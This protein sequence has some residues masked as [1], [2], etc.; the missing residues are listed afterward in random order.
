M[1]LQVSKTRKNI[2]LKGNLVLL[3]FLVFGVLVNGVVHALPNF[4]E[5]FQLNNVWFY[6]DNEKQGLYYFMPK[7]LKLSQRDN[8]PL[9]GYDLFRYV[10]TKMTGDAG[11][12]RVRGVITF[13]VEKT[14]PLK[15]LRQAK[16]KLK[17]KYREV[18][19]RPVPL[20]EFS[21]SLIYST[22][23]TNEDNKKSGEIFGGISKANDGNEKEGQWHRRRFTIG[24]MSNTAQVFWDNFQNDRLQ[25]S[26]SYHWKGLGVIPTDFNKSNAEELGVISADLNDDDEWGKAFHEVVNTI[27]INISAKEYPK[28]FRKNETWQKLSMGHTNLTVYCYDFINELKK[29]LYSVTV[30]VKF[31][32]L[33]NQDYKEKVKFNENDDSY[34]KNISFRLAKDLDAGY[35]YRVKRLY[36]DGRYE[37][38]KWN[39]FNSQHLDVT[40]Y[41]N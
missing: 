17:A 24:L 18:N 30:E 19:F 31:K 23:E 11:K 26:L 40:Y 15:E 36:Q 22:T 25:L 4:A 10:G 8:K 27:P 6:P 35:K 3:G 5:G 39:H 7:E 12:F 14:S 32:T 28:L 9:F 20:T 29:N 34:K 21:S 13:E 38:S 2:D 1:K 41:V 16:E 33:R 37:K